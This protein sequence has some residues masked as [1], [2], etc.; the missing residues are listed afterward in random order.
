MT[1]FRVPKSVTGLSI[2]GFAAGGSVAGVAA[3]QQISD[4]I[5]SVWRGSPQIALPAMCASRSV[6]SCDF[7][8]Q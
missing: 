4:F 6:P 7:S 3:R 1:Q 8:D 5:K 2:H